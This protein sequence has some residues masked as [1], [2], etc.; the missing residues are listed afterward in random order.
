MKFEKP[1]ILVTN[2]DGIDSPGIFA[3]VKALNYLGDIF[4]VAPDRQQSAV[5]HA[6]T[7]SNPLRVTSFHR[8]G[9]MFG[10]AVN[11]TPSDCIKLACSS[12]LDFSP[13][14]VVSGINH[15]KNTSVNVLY[16]GTV[17]A[18]TEGMLRGIPSLAISLASYNLRS[19]CSAAG[20]YAKA[21][22][23]KVLE[24]GL[25]NGTLL[26]INVPD[27]D[28]NDIKGI[29]FT[30]QS[31]SIWDDCYEKRTDPFGRNYYW[32]SG[33]YKSADDDPNSDDNAI[34]DG[35]ISITPLHFEFTNYKYLKELESMEFIL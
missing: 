1:R 21:I 5:G 16:S 24:T 30:H 29:K 34:K 3:L 18:A 19:D 2:D 25:P 33:E 15:G 7:V 9:E 27:I 17:S 13:S 12:L 10:Y 14:L 11:G 8:N 23:A 28:K 35:F 26:N 6:L 31:K 4:V 20:D 22:A 32:F